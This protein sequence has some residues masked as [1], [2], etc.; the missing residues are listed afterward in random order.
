M[1]DILTASPCAEAWRAEPLSIAEIDAHP[2][3]ARIW[4][5]IKEMQGAVEDARQEASDDAVGE[6]EAAREEAEEE[7][8]DECR[9]RIAKELAR[10]GDRI[11]VADRDALLDCLE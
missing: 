8:W 9:D 10:I 11:S 7:A 1:L 4:A 3:S 5:T 2:D 6:V